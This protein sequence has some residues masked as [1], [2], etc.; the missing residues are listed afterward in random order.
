MD[1]NIVAVIQAR[2]G[3]SR[4]PGKMLMDLGGKPVIIRTIERVRRARL[5]DR[6]VLATTE[7]EQDQRLAAAAREY[8]V[9]VFTGSEEDVLD[10]FYQAAKAASAQVCVRVTGDCPLIDP[11]VIDQVV[12]ECLRDGCDYAANALWY[13][14]PDGLDVEAFSF[15]ALET[16]WREARL[17]SDR[18]HVTLFIVRHPRRFRLRNV[19]SRETR[20]RDLHLSLD[21]AEDLEALRRIF[22]HFGDRPFSHSDLVALLHEERYADLRAM[23]KPVN[24]GLVTS[25]TQDPDR[26]DPR[27]TPAR[28]VSKSLAFLSRAGAVVPGATQTFS[29]KSSS[30]VPGASPLF[31]ERGEGCRVW[32]IDGN[33]Y[34]DLIMGLLPVILGHAHP[35]TTRALDEQARKGFAFSLPTRLEAEVAEMLCARIPCAEMA[36]F[37]K[38]GSDVTAG[39]VRVARAFTGREMVACCGYH[40]WQDWYIGTTTRD[41]GVPAAV[42]QLTRTFRYNDLGSLQALFD[43][44]PAQIACVIMEPVG[45]VEPLPGFLE[46]VRELCSRNGALLVFD[47]VITGFRTA[48]GGAQEHYGVTPDVA[49]FGKGLAN[50]LPISAVVGRRDVMKLFDEVFF[51]FTFG[52]EA[53]S[54]AVAKATL[55]VLDSEHVVEHLWRQGARLRDGYNALARSSGL[56]SV[57]Q[58]IGLPPHTVMTWTR[59]GGGDWLE[60]KSLFIQE[61]ARRGLLTFGVHNICLAHGDPEVDHVLEVYEEVFP[62]LQWA[63]ERGEAAS[64]LDGPSVLPVFR[65]P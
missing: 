51:S 59:P 39:A 63:A 37:G 13:S 16:A 30:F 5:L 26:P 49:C 11:E 41:A 2:L 31:L 58:C 40:G 60:L 33:E 29:K 4:L 35:S 20:V 15:E 23:N 27:K 56:A 8:G 21:D 48:R 44:H 28:D 12:S 10:R 25:L 7:S 6:V 17:K 18:E 47:E 3:S 50:G 9:E 64:L 36:R 65:Q 14:W 42:K 55:E 62:L 54:L 24:T 46:G 34:I 45:V 53:L 22:E 1:K 43:E 52:G 32:D 19:Q 38:N 57:T 61:T